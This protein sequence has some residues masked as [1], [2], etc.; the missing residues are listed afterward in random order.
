[1]CIEIPEEEKRISKLVYQ[2]LT[3]IIRIV[4]RRD[5]YTAN[6]DATTVYMNSARR[7]LKIS[8]YI[9]FAV[10]EIIINKESTHLCRRSPYNSSCR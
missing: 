7:R 6:I 1:M 3:N 4:A 8:L 9:K 2:G 10:I 5:V